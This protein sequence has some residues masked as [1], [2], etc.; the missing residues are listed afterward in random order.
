[1]LCVIFRSFCPE[2]TSITL[3][4]SQ[5]CPIGSTSPVQSTQLSD[6]VKTGVE[7]ARVQPMNVTEVDL[8]PELGLQLV[9]NGTADTLFLSLDPFSYLRMTFDF[10]ALPPEECVLCIPGPPI[11]F[12]LSC[13]PLSLFVL[14]TCTGT[15]TITTRSVCSLPR[16]AMEP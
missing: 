13:L 12:S 2:G 15:T 10:S 1:M 7:I 6:C 14:T 4:L 5:T 8:V 16:P 3:L 11:V 9:S